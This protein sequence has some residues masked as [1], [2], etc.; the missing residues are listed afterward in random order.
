M[1]T[2]VDTTVILL[3]LIVI[4]LNSLCF[5]ISIFFTFSRDIYNILDGFLSYD[6]FW[7]K[8]KISLEKNINALE[9]WLIARNKVVGFIMSIAS[10]INILLLIKVI[11]YL[12]R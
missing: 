1:I 8:K 10:L 2:Q 12:R 6:L 11:D 3:K 7:H 4:V 9:D 5:I